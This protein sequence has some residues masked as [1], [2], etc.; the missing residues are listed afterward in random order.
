M[1]ATIRPIDARD[2]AAVAAI[3]HRVMPSSV[4]TV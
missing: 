2:D 4:P 1:P 3:I